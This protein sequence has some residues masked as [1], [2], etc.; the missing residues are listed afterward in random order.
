MKG[1]YPSLYPFFSRAFLSLRGGCKKGEGR[2][3]EGRGGGGEDL[4][5]ET[6]H[7]CSGQ[8]C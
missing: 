5:P 4:R 1:P 3:G 8:G 2:G 7:A 6:S